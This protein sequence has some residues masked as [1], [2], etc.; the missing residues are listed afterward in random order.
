M[1]PDNFNRE[2][3][4]PGDR[5]RVGNIAE[6]VVG[7]GLCAKVADSLDLLATDG[8]LGSIL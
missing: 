6:G 4:V 8:A 2:S 1:M 5:L 3:R 7:L